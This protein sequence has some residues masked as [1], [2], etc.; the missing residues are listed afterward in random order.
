MVVKIMRVFVDA[1]PHVPEHRRLPVLVQ[2]VGTLG[3]ER[4]LWALLGLL[5]EQHVT[6][7][8]P[9][10]ASGEKVSAR[11]AQQDGN[12]DV[13]PGS[14][15]FFCFNVGLVL[16][17][18]HHLVGLSQSCSERCFNYSLKLFLEPLALNSSV[19]TDIRG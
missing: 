19:A 11:G 16:L 13:S 3:A 12:S 6:K 18:V 17:N 9:A 14:V 1:L 15:I 4:F 2:L 8:A 7:T 10:A 5:F